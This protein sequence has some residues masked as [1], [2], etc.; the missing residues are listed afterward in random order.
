MTNLPM[1][2]RYLCEVR[3]PLPSTHP[4]MRF[5]F[6]GFPTAYRLRRHHPEVWDQWRIRQGE[7]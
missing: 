5:A 3:L 7:G 6:M 1:H 4:M 2:G